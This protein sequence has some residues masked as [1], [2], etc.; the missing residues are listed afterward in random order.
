[1][2]TLITLSFALLSFS[3]FAEERIPQSCYGKAESAVE[4]RF[5]YRYDA[6]GFEAYDCQKNSTGK[7]VNCEVSASKGDGAATDTYR[8]TMDLTCSR[9]FRVDL[10]GEE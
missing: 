8:V 6:E 9:V 7:V 10:I 2:K 1:M 5:S 4:R 3:S